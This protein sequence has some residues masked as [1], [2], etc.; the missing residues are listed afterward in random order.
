MNVEGREI[1]FGAVATDGAVRITR[2]GDAVLVTPLPGSARFDV[3]I[4]WGELPW[5]L[6]DPRRIE[7]VSETGEVLSRVRAEREE[8]EVSVTCERGVFAY[9]LAR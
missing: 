2:E 5:R 8:R 4:A 6:P 9:R 1:D 3:R 7:A